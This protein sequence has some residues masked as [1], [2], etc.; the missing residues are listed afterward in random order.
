MQIKI[1]FKVHVEGNFCNFK[2]ET[3]KNILA[4][5]TKYCLCDEIVIEKLHQQAKFRTEIT[6]SLTELRLYDN[7]IEFS[8]YRK[9]VIVFHN[10]ISFESEFDSTPQQTFQATKQNFV[11]T[12]I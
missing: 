4:N 1:S 10:Y 9:Y 3:S 5:Q 7:I 2:Q 8:Q 6:F 12:N 11:H